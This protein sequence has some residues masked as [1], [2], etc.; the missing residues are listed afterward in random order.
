MSGCATG[1]IAFCSANAYAQSVPVIAPAATPIADAT[2]ESDAVHIRR[3]KKFYKELLL[4][5]KN[6]A[7]AVSVVNKT[8]IDAVG[9]TGSLQ[10]V[11][12][13]TPSVNTYQS[14]IG[15]NEPVITVRGVPNTQLAY[16]LDGIPLQSVA[17]QSG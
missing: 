6:V 7:A 10:S 17:R 1:I 15:Q 3:I 11:L 16:S 5:E 4:K 14:G 8:D 9:T 12:R 2:P 13:Q